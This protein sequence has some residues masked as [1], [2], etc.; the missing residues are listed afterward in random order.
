MCLAMSLLL[1]VCSPLDIKISIHDDVVA[2]QITVDQHVRGVIE[3]WD[4]KLR[5]H[6]SL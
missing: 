4:P 1:L 2:R 6:G 5:D 3:F